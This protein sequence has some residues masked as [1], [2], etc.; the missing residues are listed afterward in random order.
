[1]LNYEEIKQGIQDKKSISTKD[2]SGTDLFR[3]IR[4]T[5]VKFLTTPEAVFEMVLIEVS[6]PWEDNI[7][8]LNK[9]KYNDYLSGLN[10]IE[11]FSKDYDRHFVVLDNKY[12]EFI[13]DILEK[14]N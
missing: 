13:L 2:V 3:L 7:E 12:Y 6:F 14:R 10:L 8:E 5:Y 9:E 11:S 1:M 4:D